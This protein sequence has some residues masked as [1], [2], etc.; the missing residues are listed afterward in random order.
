VERAAAL[1]TCIKSGGVYAG[2]GFSPKGRLPADGKADKGRFP[3]SPQGFEETA[4]YPRKEKMLLQ[5]F[6]ASEALFGS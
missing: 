2:L 1:S 6:F 5:I 3:Q 4:S